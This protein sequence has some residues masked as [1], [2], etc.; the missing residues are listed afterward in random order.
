MLLS[1]EERERVGWDSCMI[2]WLERR[3]NMWRHP[4]LV[5]NKE[6]KG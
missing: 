3:M 5:S 6:A 4:S 1:A 2:G